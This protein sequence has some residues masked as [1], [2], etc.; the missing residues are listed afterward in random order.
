P[1]TALVAAG[2][3]RF[4]RNPMYLGL[5][6]GTAGVA[7]ITGNPWVLALLVPA[8]GVAD[9]AFI[10]PEERYLERTFGDAYRA[11]RTR[12]RRWI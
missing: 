2:P 9:A 11:Y 6:A 10:R 8:V 3:Y 1:T 4:T 12:V 5:S 7:L